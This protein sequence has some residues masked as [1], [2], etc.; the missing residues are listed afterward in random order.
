MTDSRSISEAHL[1]LEEV[2]EL[3]GGRIEGDGEIRVRGLAPLDQAG[4]EELGFLAQRRYLRFAPDS[5]AEAVL[6]SEELAGDAQAFAGRVVVTDPHRAL[7][8]LLG[9]FYPPRERQRG[10]HSTAVLETGV[11]LAEDVTVGAYAVLEEGVRVGRGTR[12][13]AHVVVGHDSVVGEGGVLHPHVVLYPGTRL[14]NRVVVHAGVALGVD[15]FGFVPAGGGQEKV[16]QVGAC[17]IED[18]VEIGANT[19]IDRGSIGNTVVGKGTKLDNHVHLGHNVQVGEGVL[20]AAMVGISGSTRIGDRVMFGG[21]VGTAGHIEIGDG[22]RLG[23]QAGV[24]GDIPPGETVSGYP[25][26]NHREY[27]KAMAQL[28]RL[29]RTLKRMGDL[30]K[31]LQALETDE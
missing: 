3:V 8:T 25:A 4:P 1:K 19:T 24:V 12:I 31:R 5:R 30:E 11:E 26:R 17:V 23:G 28:F 20:M 14:G 13:G 27:M 10:I 16:P 21:Q 6:V 2:A 9:R 15:G 29:P 18:D 7:P 22:A